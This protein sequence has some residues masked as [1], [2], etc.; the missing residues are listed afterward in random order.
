M[1]LYV[2][3][4]HKMKHKKVSRS[5][6]DSNVFSYNDTN[7]YTR[8]TKRTHSNRHVSSR[9]EQLQNNSI[10]IT[11][12]PNFSGVKYEDESIVI[13]GNFKPNDL[14]LNKEKLV[15]KVDVSKKTISRMT[16]DSYIGCNEPT[17]QYKQNMILEMANSIVYRANN[18]FYTTNNE[19][20]Y[21]PPYEEQTNY[22]SS[23]LQ[24]ERAR[25]FAKN[26]VH[27]YTFNQN[28]D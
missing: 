24:N 6:L 1:D 17:S 13:D 23:S 14:L 12:D 25:D 26:I 18:M 27:R 20:E 15:P 16:E 21:V 19:D 2:K 7:N 9:N 8:S 22:Q 3:S 10:F 4:N 28:Q 5:N 11:N